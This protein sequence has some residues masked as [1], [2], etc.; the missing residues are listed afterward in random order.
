MLWQI[1]CDV[2]LL[3]LVAHAWG[4]SSP[5]HVYNVRKRGRQLLGSLRDKL[6]LGTN[7]KSLD[8]VFSI[9]QGSD[10]FDQMA[11]LLQALGISPSAIAHEW[12][13]GQRCQ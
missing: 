13:S 9:N 6:F 5:G 8:R 2:A 4:G 10:P 11:L 12:F 3:V 1:V 7:Q